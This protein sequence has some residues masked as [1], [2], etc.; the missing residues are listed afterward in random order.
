MTPIA[1]KTNVVVNQICMCSINFHPVQIVQWARPNPSVNRTFCGGPG[2]AVI[3]FSAKSP[4]AK[5]RLPRTL[6][7]RVGTLWCA[8][9]V[10]F[11][12]PL[13]VSLDRVKNH[14][15]FRRHKRVRK[16]NTRP[17]QHFLNPHAHRA[18]AK[19]SGAPQLSSFSRNFAM[20]RIDISIG[21]WR[22][23][24]ACCTAQ[25][26][27]QR[28]LCCTVTIHRLVWAAPPINNRTS[29]W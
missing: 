18:T 4:A 11:T 29:V 15:Q 20:Q 19:N 7:L 1:S 17:V 25:S 8:K 10:E 28:G 22:F 24:P 27:S 6:G 16:T 23:A 9:S 13:Q 14:A 26:V 12:A 21:I 3:S 5:C 2:L